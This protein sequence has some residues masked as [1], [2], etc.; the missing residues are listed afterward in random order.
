MKTTLR[1]PRLTAKVV[2]GMNQVIPVLDVL[3]ESPS[4]SDFQQC[5]EDE[6]EDALETLN[7]IRRMRNWYESRKS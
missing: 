2:R 1:K 7:W 6:I 3:L 5:A 4:V